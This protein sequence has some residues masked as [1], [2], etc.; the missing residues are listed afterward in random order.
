VCGCVCV[1]E[2]GADEMLTF[3]IAASYP[4][5]LLRE[6]SEQAKVL[7][8]GER[9]P[10]SIA[11]AASLLVSKAVFCKPFVLFARDWEQRRSDKEGD[12]MATALLGKSCA[13]VHERFKMGVVTV[14]EQLPPA[15]LLKSFPN[16]ILHGH[17]ACFDFQSEPTASQDTIEWDIAPNL[18]VTEEGEDLKNFAGALQYCNNNKR[19]VYVF[20][21]VLRKS[22][23]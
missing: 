17:V 5:L 2:I 3:E 10:R 18:F 11:E 21:Q 1:E 23:N 19:D 6:Y 20:Y 22:R 16:V 7:N 8:R 12:K 15:A 14:R 13:V 9:H 4:L